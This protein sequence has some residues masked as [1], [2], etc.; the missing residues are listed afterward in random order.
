MRGDNSRSKAEVAKI[1]HIDWKN[2]KNPQLFINGDCMD[3]LRTMPDKYVELAI[4][5]P[6]YGI[7]IGNAQQGKWIAS[8]L[9]KKDWDKH[10][11]SGEY[12]Q[13]LRRVSKNQVIFGGNYFPWIWPT[14]GFAV[15]DKGNGFRGRDFAE[16]ELIF[17]SFDKN[18]KMFNHDPLANGD[19]HHKIHPTQK[20]ISLYKWLLTNYAKP[21]D[22]I[23][24]THVGSG[25]S[26]IACYELG[27]DYMGFEID[28]DYYAAATKRI[29]AVKAQGRLF[30]P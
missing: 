16:A 25:S 17:T 2:L 1:E 7:N 11:P 18:A 8:M 10:P 27:F 4:C 6:P 21:G 5:D 29:E 22:K 20:P 12:F 23:L 19:Y 24:D 14:R 9:A 3:Y 15:W 30:E 28:P 26:L 13:E